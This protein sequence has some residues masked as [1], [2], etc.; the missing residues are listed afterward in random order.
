MKITFDQGLTDGSDKNTSLKAEAPSRSSRRAD[1][2]YGQAVA[3]QVDFFRDDG[4]KDIHGGIIEQSANRGGASHGG[5]TAG[6]SIEELQNE[7]G[8]R[9]AQVLQDYMTVMSNTMSQEDFAKLEEDG[10]RFENLEPQEAVTIVDRIKVELARSGEEV[11]GYTDEVDMETLRKAVGSEGLARM[12]AARFQQADL[13]LTPDNVKK[14]VQAVQMASGLK[15]PDDREY[16][17][18]I[19]NRMKPRIRDFYLAQNSGVSAGHGNAAYSYYAG[20]V[21]GYY[22]KGAEPELSEALEGQIE[23]AIRSYG[24]EATPAAKEAGKWLVENALPF[25]KENLESYQELTSVPFPVFQEQ[26][27]RAATA[28]VL[29]GEEPLSGKLAVS[30]NFY[31]KAARSWKE[32]L[33]ETKIRQ[34]EARRQ[35][36][37]VRLRMTAEVNVKLLRSGFSIDTA[38]MED[39]LEA[40]RQAEEEVAKI[41][42]PAAVFSEQLTLEHSNGAVAKYRLYHRTCEMVAQIPAFPA[43]ILGKWAVRAEAGS[44]GQFHREGAALQGALRKAQ[45]TYETL[46]TVPRSDM[47]DSIRKAFGNI[48]EI[49]TGLALPG[50]EQNR[51]IVRILGYN[52]ME[53]N[54]ENIEKVREADTLVKQVT[55][56]MTPASILKMIRDGVNPLTH[57]LEELDTYFSSLPEEYSA[58]AQDYSRFLYGLERQGGITAEERAAYIGVYRLLYQVGKDDQAAVGAAVGAQA[59]MNFASLLSAVRSRQHK[60]MDIEVSDALGALSDLMEKGVSITE[61]ITQGYGAQWKEVLTQMLENKESQEACRRQLLAQIRQAAETEQECISM[62]SRGEIPP[63]AEN[64]LAAQGLSSR[65]GNVFQKLSHRRI[66]EAAA[67]PGAAEN[68]ASAADSAST[69]ETGA[70]AAEN[71][72][73]KLDE[74]VGRET[75]RSA[76]QA[77]LGQMEQEMEEATFR[78]TSSL[79][80]R[81][82][83]LLHKQ[84]HLAGNLAGQ[85]EYHLPMYFG[86]ELTMVRLIVRRDTQ[87]RGTV[88]ISIGGAATGQAVREQ[89]GVLSERRTVGGWPDTSSQR[90]GA[91]EQAAGDD[92]RIEGRFTLSGGKL[93]GY[94]AGNHE[95]AVGELTRIADIF[96]ENAS[97]EWE[98][99]SVQIIQ[100]SLR[101][102]EPQRRADAATAEP[103]GAELYRI[104]GT[105]LR[106]VQN[107]RQSARIGAG[108]H[109]NQL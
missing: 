33:G 13:P 5:K 20:E 23:K 29:E 32:L 86:E 108:F 7:I 51:K 59:R 107:V 28:A 89:P 109:E 55:Q 17:Y 98:V 21:A 4:G 26:A 11:A 27:I 49:L 88:S 87:E 106:T 71:I 82:L 42:F 19:E 25:T 91:R 65:Q 68:Q 6:K 67:V 41:Y 85:E 83:Q 61:Q 15:S 50:T 46:M 36:E 9:N 63:T 66:L 64:L 80:V 37:E 81:E 104:A 73:E 94:L 35:L 38:P 52:R 3:F 60:G 77:M 93:S 54:A 39:F 44:F 10:F 70:A 99:A 79:D 53:I 76:Y 62:L 72:W 22:L 47:G 34:L 12:I 56:K 69:G 30:E 18:M 103:V 43:Q 57:T 8:A 75:F 78:E 2:A 84:L 58:Q 74:P 92:G 96:C 97:K 24:F 100:G 102:R 101:E 31:E 45:E 40:L 48:D 14:T 16:R 105:F 95:E 1:S 90:R